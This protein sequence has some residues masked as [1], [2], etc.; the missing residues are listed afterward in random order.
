MEPGEKRFIGG[1]EITYCEFRI[2]QQVMKGLLRKEIAAAL[3]KSPDTVDS[4]MWTLFRKLETESINELILWGIETG[5]DRE[6]NYTPKALEIP[7]LVPPVR[8]LKK[9]KKKKK[10]K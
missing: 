8:I 4:Q 3:G 6:G 1:K 2:I 9:K 5:F 7:P 10:I